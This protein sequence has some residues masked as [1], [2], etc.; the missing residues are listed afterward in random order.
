MGLEDVSWCPS[1]PDWTRDEVQDSRVD[2]LPW[3][4]SVM[5]RSF[6]FGHVGV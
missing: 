6:K 1:G 5:K 2:E 4:L 3:R